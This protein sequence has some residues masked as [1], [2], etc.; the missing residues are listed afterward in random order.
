[1]SSIIV[2]LGTK[3]Q[4]VK[5]APVLLELDRSRLRYMLIYTGQH[6]ETFDELQRAFGTR[7]PDYRMTPEME[8]S[9]RSRFL[10]WCL[11][12]WRAVFRSRYRQLWRSADAI[13]V[14]GDTMSTLFG[15]LVGRLFGS[16]VV[17]VEAGLRSP[18]LLN[19]FPEELIRRWVSRLSQIHFCP[20]E[21][22]F[23]NLERRRGRK[24]MTAGNTLLDSLALALAR[25]QD[26]SHLIESHLIEA[27]SEHYAV[28]S[29]HRLENL[30]DPKTLDGIL[31][32]IVRVSRIVSLEFVLHP[33]TREAL[34]QTG[35]MQRLD[36]LDT[37]R[38]RPR[39][40]Y[41]TF[42]Q[43]LLR[44]DFLMTD[45]GSNQ[46]ESAMLG[47]PCLLLRKCTE[48]QDG[49]DANVTLSDLQPERILE[50]A[51]K[52]AHRS[53]VLNM[54]PDASPSQ[55]IVDVLEQEYESAR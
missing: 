4:F 52:H 27:S 50:F 37:I 26:G 49:L 13:V 28:V 14:H 55:I 45:G 41:F 32:S 17:H 35:W 16:D 48:R 33:A 5:F 15:A 30:S 20:D 21:W 43:L 22:S 11:A 19:P 47:L 36:R 40:D 39:T 23:S 10:K 46:E 51:R 42:V 38:L 31:D 25:A 54:L 44:C 1:M 8:A 18:R 12:F 3:A 53:W 24:Y 7:D 2:M 29:I 9:T 6:N 34:N